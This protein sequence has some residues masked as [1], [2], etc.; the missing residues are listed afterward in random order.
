MS[1]KNA[2]PQIIGGLSIRTTPPA[3]T[4]ITRETERLGF[5]LASL[6]E[7]GAL[8]R[9][10]AAGRPGGRVLE[11]GTGTGIATAWLLDGMDETARLV[12]ID[13]DATT[14][15]VAAR[16]LCDD[17]RLTPVVE[18]G[19]AWLGKDGH[20]R[21]DLIFADA[22]PGKYQAFEAAWRLLAVG[23]FYVVDDMSPEPDWPADHVSRATKLLDHLCTRPDCRLVSLDWAGGIA[24]AARTG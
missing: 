4:A 5:A 14:S 11:I 2:P 10:L 6:P 22:I 13:I 16:H 7:T 8:L 19:E 17:P 1:A 18:D 23:G 3:L 15:A 9:T 12:S 20:G 21:F 24:I